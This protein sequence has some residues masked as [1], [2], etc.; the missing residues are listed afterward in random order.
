M[1]LVETSKILFNTT[2]KNQDYIH[3]ILHTR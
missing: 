3:E 1:K 2:Q